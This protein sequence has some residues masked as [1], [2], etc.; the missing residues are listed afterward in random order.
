MVDYLDDLQGLLGT[1][2]LSE[3]R[4][5]LKAFVKRIVKDGD[6]IAV[7]YTLPITP[8][9]ATTTPVL[10]SFQLGGDRG[11]RTPNLRIA[12]AALSQLS[13]IPT[14]NRRLFEGGADKNYSAACIARSRRSVYRLLGRGLVNDGQWRCACE[15]WLV[16]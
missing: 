7:L 5:V 2:F 3:R 9:A 8:A 16:H 6:L 11:T 4:T 15:A 12:N 10:D 1:E 14:A 13:Y